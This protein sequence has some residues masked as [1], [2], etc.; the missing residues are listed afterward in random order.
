MAA[1]TYVCSIAHAADLLREDPGLLEVIVSNDDNLSYGN[2]VSVHIGR[3]DYI[4]AL[5]DEG[6]HELR[7]MLASARVSVETWHS[8]LDDFVGEPDI[9]ARVKNQPLR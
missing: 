9:I 1:T 3:D 7:D 6:I 5:T 4:T 2:I 8:F